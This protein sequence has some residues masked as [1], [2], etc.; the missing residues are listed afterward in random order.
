[1]GRYVGMFCIMLFYLDIYF[2]LMLSLLDVK[3][4]IPFFSRQP[5]LSLDSKQIKLGGEL[6]GRLLSSISG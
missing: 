1:M 3:L 4:Y 2:L 5:L 6:E